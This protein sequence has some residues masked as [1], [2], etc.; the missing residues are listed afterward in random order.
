MDDLLI[1]FLFA[2]SAVQWKLCLDSHP[3][4]ALDL[5]IDTAAILN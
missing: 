2:V 1:F 3:S 5:F 4:L